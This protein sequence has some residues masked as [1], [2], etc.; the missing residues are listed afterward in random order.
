MLP[1]HTHTTVHSYHSARSFTGLASCADCD[2]LLEIVKDADLAADCRACCVKEAGSVRYTKAVLELCPYK[3]AGLPQVMRGSART[4]S[5]APPAII[6][7]PPTPAPQTQTRAPQI[8]EFISKHAKS[9]KPRL[10]VRESI[11]AYPRLILS[12]GPDGERSSIRID[13]W[14]K[15]TILD[16]LKDKLAQQPAA[17]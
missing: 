14:R 17:A 11:G 10:A 15:D 8:A 6:T 9:L 12:G 3:R 4:S 13:N 7:K 5:A 16:F 1:P 2:L